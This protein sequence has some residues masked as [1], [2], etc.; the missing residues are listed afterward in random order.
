LAKNL[1]E[2]DSD[3]LNELG[4]DPT[5]PTTFTN[6]DLR[7]EWLLDAARTASRFRPNHL[8]TTITIVADTYR[9]DPPSSFLSIDSITYKPIATLTDEEVPVPF[10]YEPY[11]NKI[12]ILQTPEVYG[13]SVGQTLTVYYA[14]EHTL[15]DDTTNSTLPTAYERAIVLF[16][17]ATALRWLARKVIAGSQGILNFTRGRYSENS[18]DA[19]SKL[20]TTASEIESDA[21][22][23]LGAN[24]PSVVESAGKPSY[25]NGK[26][27]RLSIPGKATRT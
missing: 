18:G 14:K 27:Y 3:L 1:G 6:E 2:L 25:W 22:D 11:N 5:S 21:R 7:R 9:Y 23:I 15:P 4:E 12:N 17:V 13:L 10:V 26:E 8:T 16:A 19:V 24:D 20:R